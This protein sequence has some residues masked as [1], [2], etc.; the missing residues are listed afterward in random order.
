MEIS[1]DKVLVPIDTPELMICGSKS[2]TN[3]LL[4][5]QA[6]FPGIVL[7]NIS[8]CD[9][10][11]VMATALTQRSGVIDIG[12]AGTA[13]RFLT[14]YF[15][16]QE[17]VEVVLTGSERMQQ[18]PI[19]I[20]VEALRS[21]GADIDYTNQ[22]GYPPLA[23]KGCKINKSHV[24]ISG[25][26]SSQ[27]LTALILMGSK[28]P[29]GLTLDIADGL[30]SLPYLKMTQTLIEGIGGK[31]DLTQERIVVHPLTP[32]SIKEF[33]I[34][35]DWSSASYW[36][37]FIALSQD[38]KIRMSY[39]QGES[40]QGDAAVAKIYE[41]L[42][43][44]THYHEDQRCMELHKVSPADTTFVAL[45][46]SDTPDLAQTIAVTCAGL[47]MACHLRGLHTLKIKE[48]DRLAALKTE[49]EKLGAV[50]AI[51]DDAL[52]LEPG[53]QLRE[54]Q[55]IDT[56][57]DHRMAMAFAPLVQK[58][59]LGINEAQVV[60]KSYPDFWD[61]LAKAGGQITFHN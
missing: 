58:I 9:D 39:Y 61:D 36:Y 56:Y 23:I 13:M 54:D 11:A 20:L 12:H 33:T 31:V 50:V 17:G 55:C 45:D 32:G 3:R 38:S 30:T 37:G 48:T 14:A 42:G 4:I 29:Q 15:A 6:M 24:R 43:V 27:Y 34:G 51:T 44:S 21:L 5:L 35:S 8:R 46:L 53:T 28:L 1:L 41:A 7:K 26:V 49:L 19:A 10:S 47:G 16:S 2:E 22:D 18:R 40:I 59:S 60:T 52:I 57:H 25:R